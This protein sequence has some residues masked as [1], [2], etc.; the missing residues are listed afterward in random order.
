MIETRKSWVSF[1]KLLFVCFVIFLLIPSCKSRK[2]AEEAGTELLNQTSPIK[3]KLTLRLQKMRSFDPALTNPLVIRAREVLKDR[4]GNYYFVSRA[5]VLFLKYYGNGKF[6]RNFVKEG[7]GPGEARYIYHFTLAGDSIY[8]EGVSKILKFDLNGKLLRERKIERTY[9][10]FETLEGEKILGT[11]WDISGNVR[12]NSLGLFDRDENLL[13]RYVSTNPIKPIWIR[14]EEGGLTGLTSPM[15][16]PGLVWTYDRT[17]KII[18]YGISDRY[19]ILALNFQGK[20]LLS[21]GRKFKRKKL[22]YRDREKIAEKIKIIEKSQKKQLIKKLPDRLMYFTK[23]EVLPSGY[24][25]VYTPSPESYSMDIF[26]GKGKY[27]Y[28]LKAPI[29]LSLK[30]LTVFCDGNLGYL[31]ETDNGLLFTEY[32]VIKPSDIFRRGN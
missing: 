6:V 9:I 5:G 1:S 13:K 27:L 16:I 23:I 25:A 32:R 11:F 21:F 4:E 8:I 2:G 17:R 31:K 10:P 22:S 30:K 29:G 15:L 14:Y 12:K 24:I 28:R 3:G 18:Y 26:N 20:K 7:E 19:E